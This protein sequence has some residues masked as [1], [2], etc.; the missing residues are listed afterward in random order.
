MK[1]KEIL[2]KLDNYMYQNLCDRVEVARAEAQAEYKEYHIDAHRRIRRLD[3]FPGSLEEYCQLRGKRFDILDVGLPNKGVLVRDWNN[4]S[5][6]KYQRDNRLK[7]EGKF[8]ESLLNGGVCAFIYVTNGVKRENIQPGLF[9][10]GGPLD[11]QMRP[12]FIGLP[13]RKAG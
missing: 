11:P 3:R 12:Y 13:V 5:L 7:E 10:R 2:R 9:M 8:Y 6:L 1:I 4:P